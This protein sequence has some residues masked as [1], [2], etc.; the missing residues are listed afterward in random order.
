[1]T[2][3]PR[4]ALLAL[5]L[6]A[7]APLPAP[8][9]EAS[10]TG[11]LTD[12]AL[13]RVSRSRIKGPESAPVTI[14]ELSD[15]QCPFCREFARTTLPAL[16]SAYLSTGKARLVFF[17]FPLPSH[18]AAWGA[19]EAALCAGAQ[20]AFWPMHDRLFEAQ[21]EWSR[22]ARPLELFDRYAAELGLDRAAF[23]RCTREDQVAPLLSGDLMQAAGSGANATPTFILNG[24]KVLSGAIPFAELQAAIEEMLSQQ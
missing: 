16:D 10:G 20:D 2:L 9:Q 22:A 12:S 19:A 15:F 13:A 7:L 1:M 17:N 18:P 21:E 3:L 6:G 11:A 8:A 23:Q 4:A 5:L 14:V 24:Q